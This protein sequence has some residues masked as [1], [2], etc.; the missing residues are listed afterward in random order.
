MYKRFLYTVYIAAP[1]VPMVVI[2]VNE[3][4]T[5]SL[6][7][8]SVITTS[9]SAVQFF[10]QTWVKPDGSIVPTSSSINL[11][12]IT[13]KETGNYVCVTN[14]VASSNGVD[15]RIHTN[16]MVV[17]NCMFFSSTFLGD[18]S[19]FPFAPLDSPT[20]KSPQ[21][22]IKGVQ[23]DNVQVNCTFDG[24]PVPTITW[25][26][27]NGSLLVNQSRFLVQ[28]TNTSTSLII[29]FLSVENSGTYKCNATNSIGMSSDYIQLTVLCKLIV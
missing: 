13:R 28:F 4:E 11:H 27:P 12:E 22:T 20:I 17:I 18:D 23:G 16:V 26:S 25:I 14:L 9:P 2:Y 6:N 19:C 21:P 29:S 3:N 10:G 8:S 7:C 15:R 24:L 5:L 1:V